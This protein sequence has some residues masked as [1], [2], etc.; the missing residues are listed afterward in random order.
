MNENLTLPLNTQ[1]LS[2]LTDAIVIVRE[3]GMIIDCNE[4]ACSLL[5][6]EQVTGQSI[7][8]FLDFHLLLDASQTHLLMELKIENK[9]LLEVKSRQIKEG[10]YC[11]ILD[12]L[13]IRNRA[14]EIKR[15][16]NQISNSSVEGI[17]LYNKSEIIDCDETLASMFGYTLEDLKVQTMEQLIE[18]KSYKK[19]MDNDSVAINGILELKGVRKDGT[20]FY[21]EI[22][23]YPY[24]KNG[25]IV[26]AAS[27]KDITE[28]IENEH[29][30]EY[31]A[32][33][34]ELT[35]LPNRN[36]FNKV[37][38]EAIVQANEHK[39]QI[40]V[41]FLDID[42]FKEINDTL[43]YAFGDKLLQACAG[44]LKLFQQ[45]DTF[46][47]RMSGDEFL[48]LGRNTTKDE[49]IQLAEKLIEEFEK[50]ITIDSYEV[51]T[52]VSIGI[53]IFPENGLTASD[54]IKHADSA[55]YVIK[56]KHRNYYN[57]FESSISE[58]F[59][60]ML[61]M[62]VE[63]RRAMKEGQFE[64]YYQPQ[65]DL[66]KNEV[67]GLEALIRWNH[68]ERGFISPLEFI[69]LAEK[70]GL[71]IE[72]GDWV[73]SEACRQN[74][75]WQ[76]KGFRPITVSVNLSAKQFYHRNLVDKIKDILDET[77]LAP[78]YLELEITERMAMSNEEEIIETLHS[79]RELGVLVSIDD[80]GTGYSS[81]KYL[82]VFP[83]TKLKIDKMFLNEQK[84]ENRA[85]VKSIIHMSHSLNMKV[86]AEGV[87][88]VE[89][90]KFLTNERCDEMQGY[91]FSR[92][93]PPKQLT[94]FLS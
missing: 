63:M 30:I 66:V 37:L 21:I 32:Y 82:S 44:R 76:D 19:L 92:P 20:L 49:A 78:H 51:Y 5:N 46:I 50:P 11:L 85:I 17:V 14:D 90:L 86:I 6:V 84:K 13:S 71:I 73:I 60:S 7:D 52:T 88:T 43:G 91:L 79:L 16:I 59:K 69:P 39:E 62:E 55:M 38:K 61:T 57:I 8:K 36:F 70:T 29:K 72:I 41:F 45:V 77:G 3:D 89:Q 15:Y 24:Y 35:D 1:F 10:V 28:R 31:M 25:K 65:K 12:E 18:P 23:E 42:Y 83:I 94:D 40:A 75:E 33:Y 48:I 4:K 58:N 53:S 68:P 34:D 2:F 87:E 64:L 80:F 67:V 26:R 54:L 27:V 56:E 47:A 81:F 74:K 9:K 22:V 93:L